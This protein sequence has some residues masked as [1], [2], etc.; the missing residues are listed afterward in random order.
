MC[1][2]LAYTSQAIIRPLGD[3]YSHKHKTSLG[4]DKEV[5]FHILDYSKPIKFQSVKFLHDSSP[6][7]IPKFSPPHSQPKLVKGQ[8]CDWVSH[9]KDHGFDLHPCKHCCQ[10]THSLKKFL[11]NKLPARTRIH[12]WWINSWQWA[13]IGKKIFQSYARISSRVWKSLA[14]NFSPSYHLISDRGELMVIDKF[15][16]YIKH[17]WSTTWTCYLSLQSKS[18]IPR[19]RVLS[20]DREAHKHV[21][22]WWPSLNHLRL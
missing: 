21:F 11:K 19:F 1:G 4:Y 15:Q 5:F 9:V 3:L 12:L 18:S 7:P 8:H 14:V 20:R 13:L 10:H 2:N 6:S 16:N 22:G 17:V